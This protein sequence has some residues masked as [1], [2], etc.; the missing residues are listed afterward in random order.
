MDTGLPELPMSPNDLRLILDNLL[1]N[2]IKYTSEGSIH[3]KA[4]CSHN[5]FALE[6]QDTGVG[7]TPEQGKHLFER[8]YRVDNSRVGP[9]AQGDRPCAEP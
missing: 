6:V 8:F 1:A 2:T 4:I 3:V 5:C 9:V 7:F